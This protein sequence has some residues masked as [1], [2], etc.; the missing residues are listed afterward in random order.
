MS[1][2]VVEETPGGFPSGQRGQTV[3]L[4]VS[5]SQVRILYPPLD[6]IVR[7]AGGCSLVVKPQPSK[8]KMRVRFPSPALSLL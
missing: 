4:M 1:G 3:N 6:K 7:V 8:L 2:S 5:P